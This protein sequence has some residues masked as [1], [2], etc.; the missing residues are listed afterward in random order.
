MKRTVHYISPLKTGENSTDTAKTHPIIL[1]WKYIKLEKYR[2]YLFYIK[3]IAAPFKWCLW[4]S[5]NFFLLNPLPMAFVPVLWRSYCNNALH[6]VNIVVVIQQPLYFQSTL[7][8]HEIIPPE[9][10]ISKSSMNFVLCYSWNSE[11]QFLITEE[12][13]QCCSVLFQYNL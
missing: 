2:T 3:L 1:Q 6:I 13:I 4:F 5:G 12:L 11:E 10:I 9:V 8:K 7:C